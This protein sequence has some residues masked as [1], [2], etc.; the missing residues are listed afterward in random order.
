MKKKV[1]NIKQLKLKSDRKSNGTSQSARVI[2]KSRTGLKEIIRLL[3]HPRLSIRFL[4][5][6]TVLKAARINPNI[7]QNFSRR[8]VHKLIDSTFI[9]VNRTTGVINSFRPRLI[10]KKRS[11]TIQ[12]LIELLG[13]QSVLVRESAVLALGRMKMSQTNQRDLTYYALTVGLRDNHPNVRAKAII[14]LGDFLTHY[15]DY[16]D[17]VWPLFQDCLKDPSKKVGRQAE[18]TIKHLRS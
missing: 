15:P 16:R 17:R 11:R 14:S 7:L 13:S 1:K 5:G 12:Q 2:A 6:K 18:K 3:G 9:V 10:E 4:A 8:A